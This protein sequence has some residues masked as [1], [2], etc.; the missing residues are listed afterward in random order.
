[1]L[2]AVSWGRLQA[3]VAILSAYTMNKSHQISLGSCLS[4]TDE[5]K[6]AVARGFPMA[7]VA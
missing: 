3:T 5:S 6:V 2:L 1:M 7:E 4:Q